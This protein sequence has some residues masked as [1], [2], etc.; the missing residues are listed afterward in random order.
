MIDYLTALLTAGAKIGR[1]MSVVADEKVARICGATK[2]EKFF[3]I[4][5]TVENVLEGIHVSD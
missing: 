2:E 5:L 4:E 1:V 3:T